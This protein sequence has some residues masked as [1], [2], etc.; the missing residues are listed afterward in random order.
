MERADVRR[1]KKPRSAGE[2]LTEQ[3]RE[4]EIE[5]KSEEEEDT[6]KVILVGIKK[7]SRKLRCTGEEGKGEEKKVGIEI[8]GRLRRN[9]RRGREV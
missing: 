3:E 6:E 2:W 1:R 7:G 4:R 5:G 9:R 8:I